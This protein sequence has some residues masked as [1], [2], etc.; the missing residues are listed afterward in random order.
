MSWV[1]RGTTSCCIVRGTIHKCMCVRRGRFG[2]L[3]LEG[4]G[5]RSWLLVLMDVFFRHSSSRWKDVLSAIQ[6]C[7]PGVVGFEVSRR[8]SSN[9][10]GDLFEGPRPAAQ[11]SEQRAPGMSGGVSA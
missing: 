2:W 6:V 4:S 5:T 3:S 8:V 10:G 11:V 1:R 9:L 7:W